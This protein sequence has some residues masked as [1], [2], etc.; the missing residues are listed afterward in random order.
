MFV[1]LFIFQ[2][3]LGQQ[4][5]DEGFKLLENGDFE[6]AETFFDAY[7]QKE[8]SNKTALICYGRAV[9]LSG[10][11]KKAIEHFEGLKGQYPQDFEIAVNYNEAFLW[12][13]QYEKARPLYESLLDLYPDSFAV[14]LGYA[15]TLGNLKEYPE[16]LEWINKTISLD[17]TNSSAMV[18]R[19]YIRLGY[20]DG[21]IKKKNYSKAEELLKENFSD[22]PKDKETLISLANLY[23]ILKEVNKAKDTYIVM[24]TTKSDSVRAL[25]G[26]SLAEHIGKNDRRALSLAAQALEK[27]QLIHDDMLKNQTRERYVQSL[28]WNSSYG[29]AKTQIDSLEQVHS[30]EPWVKALR[31]TLGMYTADFGVSIEEY[32][33]ILAIDSTSFDGNLGKANALFASDEIIPA[34][35]AAFKTLSVFPGQSDAQ[36]LVEKINGLHIPTTEARAFYTFDNGN[37]IAY[38]NQV[39][40]KIPFSTKFRSTLSYTYR[41]TENT[42]TSNQALSH[43]LLGGI[44]YKIMPNTKLKAVAG[45]NFAGFDD[46]NYAQPILDLRLQM[47]PLK[48]QNLEL[49]YQREVQNFNADLIEREIVMN[50]FGLNYNLGTTFDLGWYTQA[51]HTIQTDGN[52]RNLIFSSLYYNLFKIPAV[53]VGINYQYISFSEQ[54][55]TIYFSPEKYQAVEIF[56]DVRGSF[57]EKTSYYFNGA[58]GSQKVEDDHSSAVFRLEGGFK[59][60]FAKR[61]DIELYGK[62]SNIASATA[63]GFEFTE[64]GFKVQWKLTEAPLFYKKLLA[65]L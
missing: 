55:P 2:S 11:P 16:A 64:I 3:A 46:R 25:N 31:A 20:A 36:G 57:S 23:L 24:A 61:L 29:K 52:T 42:L 32:D 50:H 43:I 22:F 7:L 65:R 51:M 48:L 28:I 54:L 40:A 59:H 41:N 27:A 53:K 15:N 37:N 60:Q 39:S 18:S 17:S 38:G 63:T 12:D 10:E 49:G 58:A 62:Y 21:L 34:Y 9:G 35:R 6:K 47:K 30:K 33:D 44:S 56:G 19:K 4:L 45:F 1:A 14:H 13:G 8:P 26:M 5:M